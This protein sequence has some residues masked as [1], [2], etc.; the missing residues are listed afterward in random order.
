MF[1]TMPLTLVKVAVLCASGRSI[2]NH[3]PNTVVY[4]KMR[5][6]CHFAGPEPN[7]LTPFSSQY[8]SNKFGLTVHS[9]SRRGFL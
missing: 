3:L 7:R 9:V 4:D 1:T 2:Y 8:T 6:A 5:D